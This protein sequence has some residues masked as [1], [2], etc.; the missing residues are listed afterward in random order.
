MKKL[1]FFLLIFVLTLSLT[2]FALASEGFGYSV[3]PR[4]RMDQDGSAEFEIH[5]TGLG[6]YA[7]AQFELILSESVSIESVAFNKGSGFSTIQPTY[8]RGSYFFS[9]IAGR[10]EY[11]GDLICTVSI[12]YEGTEPAQITI[13]EIQTHFIVSPGDVESFTNN[14]H[15]VIEILPFDYITIDDLPVP[16][17]FLRQHWIWF[18]AG[19]AVIVFAVLIF[20]I[21][22]QQR[23]LKAAVAIAAG[24]A[25]HSA[26]DEE[27][28]TPQQ[29]E[30]PGEN[31]EKE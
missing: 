25:E 29:T 11:E 19:A 31:N 7:G 2:P 14:T 17:A 23:K 22:R 27:E 26:D 9:L 30:S 28:K 10:N 16:L 15:T 12:I 24:E 6:A 4:V 1:T 3:D 8:A 18:V 20:I 13:V 21:I 5:V